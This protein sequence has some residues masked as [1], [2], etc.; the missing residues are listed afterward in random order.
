M[1]GGESEGASVRLAAD[2][3]GRDHPSH[4]RARPVQPGDVVAQKLTVDTSQRS[5]LKGHPPAVIW[6]TGLPSA[7]KSTIANSV[8]RG[9]QGAGVHTY[10]LDG[11]NLRLGLN[12]DLGF[13]QT[14]RIENIRRV[15]EVAALMADAGLVVL[16]AMISP[17]LAQRHLARQRV[18]P[19]EFCEVFVDCP[20]AI[21]EERDAKGL[22]RRA[23][24][25]Q[26]TNFTGV[27]SPYEQPLNPEVYLDTSLRSAHESAEAVVQY[28]AT[29]GVA[30]GR[31]ARP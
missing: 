11:D 24:L 22:Y 3:S 1:S 10:L 21:A 2:L 9:L 17:Y 30:L 28:L 26:I 27:D 8:E 12:S 15:A 31:S 13:S 4:A 5:A 25:G 23:R 19:T 14:D 6:F 18:A 7:G 16:V 29:R 20:L